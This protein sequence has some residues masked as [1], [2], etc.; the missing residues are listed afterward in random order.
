[1]QKLRI[2][3]NPYLARVSIR[4]I[5]ENHDQWY[6]PPNSDFK[7]FDDRECVFAFCVD[8]ILQIIWRGYQGVSDICFMGT[9]SDFNL[10]EEKVKKHDSTIKV[11]H[12]KLY[13]SADDAIET[14]RDAYQ[15]ISNEFAS[16]GNEEIKKAIGRFEETVS[17][18]IPLCVIGP[19]TSG[20][21]T[22]VNA[23]IG[24]EVLPAKT[25][26]CTANNI[27]IEK[28]EKTDDGYKMILSH[29]DIS[30]V[31]DFEEK[32]IEPHDENLLD[33]LQKNIFIK[34]NVIERIHEFVNFMNEN[35]CKEWFDGN[36]IEAIKLAIPFKDSTL[37]TQAGFSYSIYDTPGS[38]N[39][40]NNMHLQELQSV[41][42]QQTNA[43]PIVLIPRTQQKGT[44]TKELLE[45]LIKHKDGFSM[46]YALIV[47]PMADDLSNFKLTPANF[48][49]DIFFN[50]R[51]FYVSAL[52]G[53]AA[54]MVDITE[55]N[56]LDNDSYKEYH[57]SVM[58]PNRE[59]FRKYNNS[60]KAYPALPHDLVE[61]GILDVEEAINDFAM[62]YANYKKCVSGRKILLEAIEKIAVI[63]NEKKGKLEE[64][65]EQKKGAQSVVRNLI[66]AELE[67]D[68]GPNLT[69]V[70][71]LVNHEFT[72]HKMVYSRSVRQTLST[73][74]DKHE[75]EKKLTNIIS[76][77]MAQDCQTKLYDA[78]YEEIRVRTESIL[79]RELVNYQKRTR[80]II[81]GN[82][83]CLS[84]DANIQI[85]KI[86]SRSEK[87]MFNPKRATFGGV[88]FLLAI[89]S[90]K[91]KSLREAW[92]DKAAEKFTKR[93]C[94]DDKKEM[95]TFSV[96]CINIP[97]MKQYAGELKAWR[98]QYL[99]DIA[100]ILNQENAILTQFEAEIQQYIFDIND[101]ECR[102]KNIQDSKDLLENILPLEE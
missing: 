4:V 23:L 40:E 82:E 19:Y 41:L 96:N 42:K 47:I 52:Q 97:I 91:I 62:N 54:K 25:D 88:G 86:I 75:G 37:N 79:V 26:T 33:Y 51:I 100:K 77:A 27:E 98:E 15:K 3:T 12:E 72:P 32:T 89:G 36:V 63:L 14:I 68:P 13:L 85:E 30:T 38:N 61:S 11:L 83:E 44:Q 66:L 95:G 64:S 53:L 50:I 2:D 94:G 21:S 1:M 59:S 92:L 60:V 87:P 29:N 16:C 58:N 101:L 70:F 22:F 24:E 80:R 9:V 31:I 93:V 56:W 90:L 71:V 10:L 39:G 35:T 18:K 57:R 45:K 7:K 48:I 84:S 78:T 34:E 74:L 69:K 28:I 67:K 8:D 6:M 76:D 65:L 55:N 5:D 102:L 17:T 46:P 81:A 49:T 73:L 20:K 43:L 99:D